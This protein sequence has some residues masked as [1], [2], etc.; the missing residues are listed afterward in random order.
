MQAYPNKKENTE[1]RMG[2]GKTFMGYM[3]VPAVFEE[4]E[5]GS[6]QN[7]ETFGAYEVNAEDSSPDGEILDVARHISC[8]LP[9]QVTSEADST[10]SS[11]RS[12]SVAAEGLLGACTEIFSSWFS[13]MRGAIG[14]ERLRQAR[15]REENGLQKNAKVPY[16]P[17]QLTER[18]KAVAEMSENVI[19]SMFG[20]GI[21]SYAKEKF[22]HAIATGDMRSFKIRLLFLKARDAISDEG[23][24]EAFSNGVDDCIDEAEEKAGCKPDP[25]P[26]RL[27]KLEKQRKKRLESELE[28]KR[29]LNGAQM[30]LPLQWPEKARHESGKDEHHDIVD[31]GQKECL[32]T[33]ENSSGKVIGSSDIGLVGTKKTG[34]ECFSL[35]IKLIGEQDVKKSEKGSRCSVT[36]TQ[37][38][39]KNERYSNAEEVS[40]KHSYN[41]VDEILR[42]IDE[43]IIDPYE[44]TDEI[45]SDVE[46]GVLTKEEAL[47]FAMAL[48]KY[49]PEDYGEHTIEDECD[50][51]GDRFEEDDLD[52]GDEE[53]EDESDTSQS[54]M[55]T[56]FSYNPNGF[57]YYETCDMVRDDDE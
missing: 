55:E 25:S 8:I 36:V 45:L 44:T 41:T 38:C 24:R 51:E 28:R 22:E 15:F 11:A 47:L 54:R 50:I 56:G 20:S 7:E 40:R 34:S 43:G 35:D 49:S 29:I 37:K 46:N 26:R 16:S 18:D 4:S 13:S 9:R 10:K 21:A 3:V 1:R 33:G 14:R 12:C 52:Y 57:G 19:R 6:V 31:G 39:S 27:S 2:A 23:I 17:P 32:E 53:I 42:D 48:D 30:E 5:D